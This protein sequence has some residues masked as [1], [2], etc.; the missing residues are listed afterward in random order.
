[1]N[2]RR[3]FL[4]GTVVLTLICVA[5]CSGSY[6]PPD[7]TFTGAPEYYGVGVS[8]W[9]GGQVAPVLI[10]GPPPVAVPETNPDVKI[11]VKQ[12]PLDPIF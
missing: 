6:Q 9:G 10:G 11:K 7:H 2:L 8:V 5:A 3:W 4:P 12:L 1:M